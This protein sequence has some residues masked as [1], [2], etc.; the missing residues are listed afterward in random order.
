MKFNLVRKCFV[1]SEEGAAALE[2]AIVATPF[3]ALLFA[4]LEVSLI[5]FGSVALE[6]GMQEAA[7]MVRT[8]QLQ[9]SGGSVDDFK[10]KICES[11]GA[12][13][14]CTGE[15]YI[16]VRTFQEFDDADFP[17]PLVGGEISGGF[18]FNP[19]VAGDVVLV[20]A[21]YIWNV[22]TPIIGDIMANMNG[23][24]R[25][26]STSAAFRNEPFQSILP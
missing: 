24:R 10:T 23:G 2:F 8:G 26:L 18:L 22:T 4:I 1:K 20:R 5:Y 19:G 13:L 21:F 11:A 15:L 7:R 25:L 17:D 9:V 12:L 16:D 14:D 3:F 6:N